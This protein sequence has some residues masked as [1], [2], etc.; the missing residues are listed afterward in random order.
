MKKILLLLMFILLVSCIDIDAFEQD[1]N[2]EDDIREE[3][4][5]LEIEIPVE[6]DEEPI[7]YID[8]QITLKFPPPPIFIGEKD[9]VPIYVEPRGLIMYFGYYRAILSRV[10]VIA[11]TDNIYSNNKIPTDKGYSDNRSLYKLYLVEV[12]EGYGGN[13]FNLLLENSS[14]ED[15]MT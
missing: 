4:E 6:Y 12:L 13:Y 8:T 5:E 1:N 10:K 7:F 14:L 2:E 15:I 3:Q 11:I 9:G